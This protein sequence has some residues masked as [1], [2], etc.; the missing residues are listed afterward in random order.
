MLR[1]IEANG[2]LPVIDRSFPLEQ[3]GDAFRHQ[4]SGRHFGKIVLDI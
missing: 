3:I 1:A 4:A 2:V